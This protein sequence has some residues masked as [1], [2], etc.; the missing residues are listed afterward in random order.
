MVDD[1]RDLTGSWKGI[2][3]YPRTLPSNQ[4]DAELREHLG[5]LDG[6]TFEHG[7]TPRT[8]GQP[9]YAIIRGDRLGSSVNFTKSYDD[10]TRPR[11]PVYY[12]GHVTEDGNEITGI[13]DI[14]GV[15]SGTFIMVRASQIPQAEQIERAEPIELV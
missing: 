3:S 15:W 7:D 14:P 10:V 12:S 11:A 9:M 4:F 1:N 8:K 2:F 5:L 6:D 13:W